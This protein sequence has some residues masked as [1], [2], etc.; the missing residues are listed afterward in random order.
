MRIGLLSDAHG[1]ADAVALGVERLQ[2]RVDRIRFAGDA[3]DQYRFSNS[4][5]E[6]I[7]ELG[8]DYVV[9]NHE[10]VVLGPLGSRVRAASFVKPENLRF[11]AQAPRRL[12]LDLDGKRLLMVHGSPWH[13]H[14]EYIYPSSKLLPRF[15]E[16]DFDYVVYGHTHTPM[17]HRSGRVLV[18]NPGS[19]GTPRN[20]GLD[21]P[22]FSYAILDTATDRVELERIT[23]EELR[24][25]SA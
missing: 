10:E 1:N 5:V 22:A 9:G 25:R 18:I 20:G 14:D 3:M 8:I 2:G 21:S 24:V 15:A 7:R 11:V 4:V 17:V 16:L 6:I 23:E 19:I 13:P 12:E